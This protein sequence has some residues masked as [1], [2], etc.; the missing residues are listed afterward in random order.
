MCAVIFVF[1]FCE[2]F[3]DSNEEFIFLE[4]HRFMIICFSD[5]VCC[6]NRAK[7]KQEPKRRTCR[8]HKEL[9]CI[10]EIEKKCFVSDLYDTTA[11]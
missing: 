11:N 6:K 8:S 4:Q 9:S 10:N 5:F 7:I 2:V 3:C 1:Y